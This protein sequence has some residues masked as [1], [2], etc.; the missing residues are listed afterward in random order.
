MGQLRKLRK[1]NIVCVLNAL[2]ELGSSSKKKLAEYLGF[3]TALMTNICNDLA[4][5]GIISEGKSLKSSKAG[6][7]EVLIDINFDHKLIA[8]IT[9][10]KP[11]TTIVISNLKPEIKFKKTIRTDGENIVQFLGRVINV[12][13]DYI[14]DNKLDAASF[15]G[16][17][18]GVMGGINIDTGLMSKELWNKNVDLRGI[19]TEFTELPLFFQNDTNN[20]AMAEHFFSHEKQ[21]FVVICHDSGVG[22]AIFK[23]GRLLLNTENTTGK[24]GHMIVNPEGGYCPNC[25]RRGCLESMTSLSTIYRE[26]AAGMQAGIFPYL[27]EQTAGNPEK[28]NRDL[29]FAAYRDG[30]IDLSV[31]F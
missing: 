8:G 18:I 25:K 20:L 7:R 17:G 9:L 26:I 13:N 6:R 29:L 24:I 11:E 12:V 3:S 28:L 14:S 19:L 30:S 1:N 16:I 23:D 21:N 4:A 2:Y 5:E 31:Y 27:K 22:G 10:L 15:L